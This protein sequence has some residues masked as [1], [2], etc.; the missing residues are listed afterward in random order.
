MEHTPEPRVEERTRPGRIAALWHRLRAQQPPEPFRDSDFESSEW[1]W[2][3][4][5]PQPGPA[6]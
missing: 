5:D 4:F 3:T 1:T 2:S 6:D